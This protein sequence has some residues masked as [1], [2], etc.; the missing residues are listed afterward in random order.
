MHR[1]APRRGWKDVPDVKVSGKNGTYT[2][3]WKAPEGAKKYKI[4]YANKPIVPWLGFHYKKQEYEVDPEKH[5][6][7][8]AASNVSDE[9]AP[10]P[11]GREQTWTVKGLNGGPEHHFVVKYSTTYDDNWCNV[12]NGK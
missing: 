11:A 10:L 1:P 3:T 2:L 9:P 12:K 6:P 8:F 5:V 4:K 7:F